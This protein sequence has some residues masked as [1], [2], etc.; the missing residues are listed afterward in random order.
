[1]DTE[2]LLDVVR[3]TTAEFRKGAAVT[4]DNRVEGLEAVHVY[5]M[6]HADHVP[7]EL[8]RVD[9]HFEIV[10]V[11]KQR[12][13]HRRR[14]PVPAVHRRARDT[15]S[16]TVNGDSFAYGALAGAASAYVAVFLLWLLA[17]V[18]R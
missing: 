6:P 1:M 2:L 8:E 13:G 18:W 4:T 5:A 16:V 11:D 17:K 7:P 10:G 14:D 15:G 3:D 12:A 9:V